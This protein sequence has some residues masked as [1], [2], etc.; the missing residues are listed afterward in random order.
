MKNSLSKYFF[1]LA[2]LAALVAYLLCHFQEKRCIDPITTYEVLSDGIIIEPDSS[3]AGVKEVKIKVS[4][5]D[6]AGAPGA[7]LLDT[8]VAPNAKLFVPVPP[9]VLAVRVVQTYLD[10]DGTTVADENENLKSAGIIVGLDVVI[11]E[12]NPAELLA[13][14]NCCSLDVVNIGDPNDIIV[15]GAPLVAFSPYTFS[16][17]GF[18]TSGMNIMKIKIN[19]STGPELRFV[20]IY[21]TSDSSNKP[22]ILGPCDSGDGTG[23]SDC[24]AH[25]MTTMYNNTLGLNFSIR[26]F[27]INGNSME[28]EI[29]PRNDGFISAYDCSQG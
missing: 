20:V 16:W 22:T 12:P 9:N 11:R 25:M 24:D 21:D 7:T 27:K 17:N 10:E 5:L 28:I 2:A 26:F 18:L 29:L 6:S 15:N 14:A 8:T 1:P 3:V 19:S 13:F 23:F 4:A